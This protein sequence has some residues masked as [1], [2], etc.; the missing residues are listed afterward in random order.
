M[1]NYKGKWN[2]ISLLTNLKGDAKMRLV[3]ALQEDQWGYFINQI[4]KLE[5]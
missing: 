1:M 5:I 3:D 4:Y 2:S